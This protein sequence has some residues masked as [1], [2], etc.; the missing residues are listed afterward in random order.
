MLGMGSVP[1]QG[2]DSVDNLLKPLLTFAMAQVS[3]VL[4]LSS[5]IFAFPILYD[6]LQSMH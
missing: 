4:L 2:G 3:C 1:S 6:A 5:P